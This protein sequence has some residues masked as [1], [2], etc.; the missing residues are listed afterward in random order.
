MQLHVFKLLWK[1]ISKISYI[2]NGDLA[3]TE[4]F[5]SVTNIYIAIIYL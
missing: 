1:L 5:I 2:E 4:L 3:K